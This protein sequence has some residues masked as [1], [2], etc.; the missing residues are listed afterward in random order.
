MVH[1]GETALG[2]AGEKREGT[3]PVKQVKNSSAKTNSRMNVDRV[4]EIDRKTQR[5]GELKMH[6]IPYDY[7]R[8][9]SRFVEG[10]F[11]L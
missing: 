10:A 9:R 5:E 6:K 11:N 3:Q 1:V 8:Q 2:Y 7:N 4:Y